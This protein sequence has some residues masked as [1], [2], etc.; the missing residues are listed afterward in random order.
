M[1]P[2][3]LRGLIAVGVMIAGIGGYLLFNKL[4]LHRAAVR[5]LGIPGYKLGRP[6]VLYFTMDGCV[7][8]KTTQRPAL[9][10]LMA[11][12]A[13]RVQLVEVDAVNQPEMTERWGVLSV[14]TTFIIDQHGRPRRVNHGVTLTEKLLNQL[15]QA[16]GQPL[17]G[18]SAQNAA[19]VS[20]SVQGTD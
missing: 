16:A 9:A 10:R 20:P 7:P 13:G 8:C 18:E 6:A 12:T 15:E 19:K 11:L 3:L 5:N 4:I 1:N 17:T 2:I 14:P